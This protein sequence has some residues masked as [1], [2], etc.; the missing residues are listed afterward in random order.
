MALL[1]INRIVVEHPDGVPARP[2]RRARRAVAVA[3]ALLAAG[4]LGAGLTAASATPSPHVTTTGVQFVALNP[5]VT[6]LN[7]K[8]IALNKSFSVIVIGGKTTVPTNA[9]TVQLSV[10]AGGTAA[11]IVNIFPAGNPSGGSGQFMQWAAGS[12]QTQTIVE[13]VGTRD[14]LTFADNT[15]AAKVTAVITGYSTQVADGD[16]SPADGTAGQVLTNTGTG[17][18]WQSVGHFLGAYQWVGSDPIANPPGTQTRGTVTCPAG[19][20]VLSGGAVGSDGVP[21]QEIN[22]SS[23]QPDLSGWIVDMDNTTATAHQFQVYAVCADV[24]G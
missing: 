19:T 23:P 7:N 16:I 12:S 22:S 6:V 14:E 9:T 3:V 17:V 5:P 4:G 8:A 24:T 18:E 21:G 10:T 11:G 20:S 15:G 13:N 2:P 1:T